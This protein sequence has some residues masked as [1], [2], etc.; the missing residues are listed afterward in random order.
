MAT[1]RRTT[2]SRRT[3]LKAGSA[4]LGTLAISALAGGYDRFGSP[5]AE[6]QAASPGNDRFLRTWE[7]TDK[8]VADGV[9]SRTWIWGPQGN[10]ELMSEPYV[11]APGGVRTCQYFDK[12]RMEDS[13]WRTN[14]PP[15]DV[16]T[17]LLSVELITG[18][19]QVG[20]NSFEQRSPAQI[21][22]AGDA[23]DSNGPQYATFSTLLNT[24]P[25]PLG[26]TI[27]ERVDRAANVTSD[28][29]LASQ[30]VT[31]GL[32]DTVTNHGIA[33]P[34]WEFMN[35]SGI[36]YEN[37]QYIQAK[38]FVDPYFATGRPI[39]E[40]Y[41]AN[42]LVGGTSKLVLIQAFER[43]CLTYT[44]SNSPEWRVEMGNIGQ[45]YSDWMNSKDE[46]TQPPTELAVKRV[47]DSFGHDAGGWRVDKHPRFVVDTNGDGRA[48]VV[49]FGNKGVYISHALADGSFA[50][51]EMMIDNFGHDA[52]GWRV[53]KHPRV[54]ADTNGNG[55]ADIVGF[56][57]KGVYISR[58]LPDGSYTAPELVVANFGYDA[59]G[60][61]VD[62]HPRYVVDVNGNGRA[63]I[64]GFGN[65]G[66]WISHALANGT[67]SAPVMVVDN[68][69]Y[70]AGGWR[71]EKHPRF[72][73][74]TTGNGRADIVGFGNEGVWVS[75]AQANGSYAAPVM[76]VDN[77]AYSAGGWRVEK[78]PRF[79]ADTNGNGRADIVGFGNAGVY[80][81]L[82]LPD[83]SYSVPEMVVDNFGYNAGGWRVEKHPRFMA[84]TTGNGRADIVGFGNTSVYVSRALANGSYSAPEKI[85]DNY[86][87][88]SGGWRVEKHPRVVA[89][90]NAD[91]RAD[92]LGF[93]NKGV[94]VTVMP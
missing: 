85:V 5:I 10:T 42:V 9:V 89:D 87:Y 15:W 61:R 47:I 26:T 92:I 90:V 56:G 59:G 8:P 18:K 91:G 40:A 49:G 93:G 32:V 60:W 30:S 79:M 80:V 68:F 14:T 36:V 31:V 63:D 45:H 2:Y 62:R 94:Y 52:G 88:N 21:N 48:D 54:L 29:G 13:S 23:D 51:P 11:E 27:T 86:A 1:R 22:V 46:P 81:S 67:Y 35:S 71:V 4:A 83:G 20:D 44:P 7:R 57:N 41:W 33:A 34:F 58:A 76:V 39:A 3:I 70:N 69:G 64:V 72:M 55:L 19:R 43:R 12:A 75:R 24:A 73:A 78:H 37:G 28:P 16:T 53:D 77:Y 66:V 25:R 17:G 6:I 84:D 74:D 38:L 50:K 82:A 65:E